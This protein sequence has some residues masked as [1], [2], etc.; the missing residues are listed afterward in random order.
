MSDM[1]GVLKRTVAGQDVPFAV[2]MAAGSDGIRYSGAA[3]AW[4]G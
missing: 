1:G 4:Q 2:G 3:G